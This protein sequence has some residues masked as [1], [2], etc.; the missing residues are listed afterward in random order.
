M[1]LM[2]LRKRLEK[3]RL[4]KQTLRGQMGM[5]LLEI[6]IVLAILA[7]VMGLLVGP[8]VFEMFAE[9]KEGLAKTE[10]KQLA[11]ESYLRWEMAHPGGGCPGSISEITKYANKKDGKDPWGNE[12][13]MHCGGNAPPG[14]N[15]GISSKGPDKKEGTQDD[16]KSWEM[17]K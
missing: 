8:R 11:Y 1:K 13:M 2:Q 17:A 14:T 6:M 3:R 16:I 12:Y 4:A 7:L 15:F 10:V 9:S 5:T